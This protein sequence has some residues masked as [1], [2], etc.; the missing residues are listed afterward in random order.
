MR[1][2]R[3]PGRRPLEAPAEYCGE[4]GVLTRKGKYALKAMVRLAHSEPGEPVSV[5]EISEQERIP[6][7]FLD[8]ILCELRNAGLVHSKM[9]RSGGYTLARQA[10][11]IMVG[12]VVRLID[13]PLAPVPCASKTCYRRCDDCP[14][15]DA[16]VVRRVMQDAQRALSDVLDNCSLAHMHDMTKQEVDRIPNDC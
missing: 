6:K 1:R 7:K 16:C 15:E 11:E 2:R 3:R 14:D 12:D 4:D 13:G 10:S 5:L 8:S 9:G